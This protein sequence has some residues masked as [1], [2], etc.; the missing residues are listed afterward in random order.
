[1]IKT[2]RMVLHSPMGPREGTLILDECR[3]EVAGTLRIL[4]HEVPVRGRRGADGR[5]HLSHQ[6]ITTVSEYPC[7]SVLR[8]MDG[9]LSGE[10]WMDQSGAPWG[11]GRYQAKTVMPWSGE[12]LEGMEATRK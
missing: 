3:G 12:Q 4:S 7:Q 1:M 8:D 6:I 2:Y 9:I 10:L 11:C 5:L